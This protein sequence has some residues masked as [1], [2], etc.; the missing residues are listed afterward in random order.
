MVWTRSSHL[1]QPT[2]K[3]SH[4]PRLTHALKNYIRQEGTGRNEFKGRE[5]RA[6]KANFSPSLLHG[7]RWPVTGHHSNE[8]RQLDFWFNIGHVCPPERK[9]KVMRHEKCPPSAANEF[10]VRERFESVDFG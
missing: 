9:A 5:T 2:S 1:L 10:Y 6:V 3:R 4:G 7:G 8:T